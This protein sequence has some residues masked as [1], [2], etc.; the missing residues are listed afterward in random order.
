MRLIFNIFWDVLCQFCYQIQSQVLWLLHICLF[1]IQGQILWL[2]H[3]RDSFAQNTKANSVTVT[4]EIH[5]L[6]CLKVAFCHLWLQSL[7]FEQKI[8]LVGSEKL[9][10]NICNYIYGLDKCN[11]VFQNVKTVPLIRIN[12]AHT[13]IS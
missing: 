10:G 8:V 13:K 6:E 4:S 2:I 11:T 7:I 1:E 9:S 3:C 5:L 12:K